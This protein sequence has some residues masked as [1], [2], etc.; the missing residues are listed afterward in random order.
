MGLDQTFFFAL[1]YYCEE[2]SSGESIVFVGD[3][4]VVEEELPTMVSFVV[5]TALVDDLVASVALNMLVDD[6]G[7]DCS[8]FLLVVA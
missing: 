4:V 1:A 3:F 8:P 6:V 2:P 7:T 5:P